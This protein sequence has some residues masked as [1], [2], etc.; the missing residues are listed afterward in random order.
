MKGRDMNKLFIKLCVFISKRS[1]KELAE[2]A[3][4]YQFIYRN[5][6][7]STWYAVFGD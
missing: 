2:R 1:Q 7:K 5:K 4:F 3:F 6:I